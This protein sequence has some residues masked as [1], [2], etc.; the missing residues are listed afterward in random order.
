MFEELNTAFSQEEILKA[1]SQLKPNKSV[2]PDRIINGF[3]SFMAKI[4]LCLHYAI[5]SIRYM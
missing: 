4:F 2:G 3:F 1:N 5:Y